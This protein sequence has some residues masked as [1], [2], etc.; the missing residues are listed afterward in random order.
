MT[1]C[2]GKA[3]QCGTALGT[4]T[5]SH[6]YNNRDSIYVGGPCRAPALHTYRSSFPFS[7]SFFSLEYTAERKNPGTHQKKKQSVAYYGTVFLGN[8]ENKECLPLFFHPAGE[9][10]HGY[11]CGV[12]TAGLFFLL[13][14][15][16]EDSCRVLDVYINTNFGSSLRKLCEFFLPSFFYPAGKINTGTPAGFP[17]KFFSEKNNSLSFRYT[18]ELSQSSRCIRT[19]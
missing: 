6:T 15:L 7:P 12:T 18:W 14:L 10:I 5:E 8:V 3:I 11:P 13:L 17:K 2:H 4:L 19:G 9:K 1:I 16:R